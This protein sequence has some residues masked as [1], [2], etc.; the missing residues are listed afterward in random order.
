VVSDETDSKVFALIP[1]RRGSKGL[2]GK[3]TKLLNGKPLISWTIEAALKSTAIEQVFVTT[4]DPEVVKIGKDYNVGI[5]NRPKELSG[6][7]DSA[8]KVIEHSLSKIGD[9]GTLIYLQPTSPLRNFKHINMAY[10]FYRSNS[11]I[12]LISVVQCSEHP[13]WMFELSTSGE[14][15]PN[16]PILPQFRQEIPKRYTPNGAIYISDIETLRKSSHR[17]IVMNTKAFIMNK[18]ESLDIDDAEDFQIAEILFDS[19]NQT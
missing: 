19:K 3:N 5:I 13:E 14:L 9:K 11:L 4:D 8:S 18:K 17:L 16:I 10:D 7:N 1:A 6:D 12:S 15:K 2:P